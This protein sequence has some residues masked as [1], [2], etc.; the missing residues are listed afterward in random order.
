M[1]VKPGGHKSPHEIK[2]RGRC[3]NRSH[4]QARFDPNHKRLFQLQRAQAFFVFPQLQ[5]GFQLGRIW[6]R[7]ENLGHFAWLDDHLRIGIGIRLFFSDR[8]ARLH[9]IH[10]QVLKLVRDL[11]DNFPDIATFLQKRL[12]SLVF[13]ILFGVPQLRK[14]TIGIEFLDRQFQRATNVL[15]HFVG[16]NQPKSET[17]AQRNDGFD[18]TR[19]EFFEVFPEGHRRIVK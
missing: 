12:H 19:T 9:R 17:D 4:N 16:K 1:H 6:H 3:E 7:L 8:F 15:D 5:L 13:R 14:I 11:I 18:K 2:D 10:R